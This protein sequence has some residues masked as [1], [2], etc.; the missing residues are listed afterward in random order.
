[1]VAKRGYVVVRWVEYNKENEDMNYAARRDFIISP[2]NV[3]TIMGI[4]AH[5]P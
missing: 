1:V 5:A 4:N 2:Q 3:D